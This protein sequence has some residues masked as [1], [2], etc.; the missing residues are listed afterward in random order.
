MERPT[1]ETRLSELRAML[2]DSRRT[3]GQLNPRMVRSIQQSL[4]VEGYEFS[5]ESVRD[6]GKRV[7]Q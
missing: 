4:A 1:R 3:D 7:H 5:E 2:H 6:V